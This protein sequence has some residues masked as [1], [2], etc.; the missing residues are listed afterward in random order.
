MLQLIGRK[1]ALLQS[2][3]KVRHPVRRRNFQLSA[4]PVKVRADSGTFQPSDTDA[5]AQLPGKFRTVVH[6][7]YAEG[8]SAEEI[9]GLLA[10]PPV[11]VRTRLRR[12]RLKLKSILGGEL[13]A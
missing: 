6:L 4:D 13:D 5:V 3:K 2:F 10:I 8:Y 1:S 12:A 11:T 9:A 7:H